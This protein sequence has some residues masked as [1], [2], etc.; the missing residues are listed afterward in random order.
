M[1]ASYKTGFKSGGIDNSALPSASLEDL[2]SSDPLIRDPAAAA[3]V[4][5][6]E[7]ARGGEIGFKSQL[8]DKTLTLNGTIYH[9]TYKDLQVQLFNATTIQFITLNAGKVTTKGAE[10]EARWRTPLE[11]LSFS[12]NVAYLK[13]QIKNDFF[14]PGP[15]GINES[16]NGT[17]GG[18]DINLKGRATGR[19]P[20]WSG[21]LAFDYT[22][23]IGESLSLQ[24]G[25][26]MVFSGSYFTTAANA[27]D[28]V[29]PSYQTFDGRISFGDIDNKWRV[30][31]VGVNLT[32]KIITQTS[33]PRPFAQGPNTFGIPVGD[34]LIVQ[35][36]RGRQI[37]VE[38][39]FKF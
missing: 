6:S 9:Y 2:G 5:K 19:A 21:N 22:A 16:T 26:N 29:Q 12:A 27:F 23:P 17:L 14:T 7:K 18:D 8:F 38:A 3:L 32:D 39:S 1:F 35:Q 25:G 34:D 31:L 24:M 20:E 15:N 37:F 30:A 36:N 28:Y 4:F 10:L 11:G 33:G 13:G